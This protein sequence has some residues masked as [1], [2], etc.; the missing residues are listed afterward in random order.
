M[1]NKSGETTEPIGALQS[2]HLKKLVNLKRKIFLSKFILD[3]YWVAQRKKKQDR[4]S[5]DNH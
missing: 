1:Q 3:I 2:F 4:L 5:I